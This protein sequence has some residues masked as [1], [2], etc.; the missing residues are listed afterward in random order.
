MNSESFEIGIRLVKFRKSLGLSQVKMAEKTNV[1]RVYITQIET[2]KTTP[3]YNVIFNLIT[4][5]NL[6]IDWLIT[7]K[8]DMTFEATE[9]IVNKLLDF[10]FPFITKMS[11]LPKEKQ[12]RLIKIFTDILE[13]D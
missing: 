9:S 1:N 11:E 8:G 5:C 6:S 12:K 13:T 4:K 10:Y 3:S 2:G 7:G